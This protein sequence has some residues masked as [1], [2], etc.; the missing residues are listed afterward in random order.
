MGKTFEFLVHSAHR[1]HDSFGAKS[2]NSER[3]KENGK[4]KREQKAIEKNRKL[5][6]ELELSTV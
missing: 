6:H 3:Q 2:N 4:R 1:L 5:E